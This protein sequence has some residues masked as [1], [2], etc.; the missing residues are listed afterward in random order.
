MENHSFLTKV[1]HD[2]KHYLPS[3]APLKDFIHH[4]TLHAF[5]KE[6]FHLALQK[7]SALFGFDTY[8]ELEEYREHL[9]NGSI[10]SDKLAFVIQKLIPAEN[11]T[12]YSMLLKN[13]PTKENK[14][15]KLGQ[16]RENWKANFG[17]D[18]DSAVH[19]ILFRVLSN[20]LDQGISS[21]HFPAGTKGLLEA[22][23]FLEKTSFTSIFQSKRV[24]AL[25]LE[26]TT[27]LNDLL[28]II[29]EKEELIEAYLF[30]QQFTHPGW[31]GMVSFL[32]DNEDALITKRP[33]TLNELIFLECLFEIDVLDQKFGE[34][35]PSLSVELNNSTIHYLANV[36][37]NEHSLLLQIWQEAFEW[38]YYDK[39]LKALSENVMNENSSIAPFQVYFC[40]DDRSCSLRRYIEEI[41]PS[42]E[43]F[44]TPG[45]FNLDLFFQ[46][47]DGKFVTKICP[48][49]VVPSAVVLEID[50]QT[51]KTK[52]LH[53]SNRNQNF[54]G[55]TIYTTLMGWLSALKLA[56]SIVKPKMTS[57]I[58][59]SSKHMDINANLII[60]HT[61]EIHENGLPIGYT[62]LQMADR[63]EGLL[64]STGLVTDF[65]DLVYFIGHGSTSVNN[66]HYAGYDCGACSG[67]PGSVNARTIAFIGNHTEVR[68]ILTERG[69]KIPLNTQFIGG[70]HDTS[71]D[72][73]VFF[74]TETLVESNS[75]IHT[76]NL[77]IF[78][79]AL[80]KNALERARKFLTVDSKKDESKVI[81]NVR[82]RS[83]SI[84]EPRPELNHATNS[85]CIVGR[86]IVSKNTFLDRRAFLNSFDYRVDPEGIYLEGVLNAVAPVAGGINLEYYFSRVDNHN[87]G[88]GSKLPHNVVG[89]FG[90]SNGVDGDLRTGLP[91]QMV[92][93]HDPMRLMVIVEH[94]PEIVLK[95]IQ[96]NSSTYNWFNEQWI[97]LMAIHPET[98]AFYRFE[99]GEFKQYDNFLSSKTKDRNLVEEL[100]NEVNIDPFT[101]KNN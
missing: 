87:L 27:Q 78:D 2:I 92:E 42:S 81:K 26:N 100:L 71:R 88:A 16:I 43:T 34:N 3:Q 18:M 58:N 20:Y 95:T 62:V 8:L 30:D 94:F 89:L 64:K 53:F 21:W 83:L 9:K 59:S 13:G 77:L 51:K 33:I 47:E 84:F 76:K 93:F 36:Y 25:L 82:N 7:A 32:E 35:W 5:Q 1:I 48:L 69:I 39:V 85:L 80:S 79:R 60:E 19:P 56:T 10:D 15:Q 4:N 99:K 57:L 28:K 61:G 46:P 49:P 72:E 86:R 6:D 91:W 29:L 50:N 24:R 90:V 38:T 98:R 66:T 41:E 23:R 55:G 70:L 68:K 31:S 75:I 101:F 11:R 96:K 22:I 17:I 65:S 52:D 63:F 40:M 44:G 67:R 12:Y 73:I 14:K 37:P 74:D 54:L 97:H 45:H